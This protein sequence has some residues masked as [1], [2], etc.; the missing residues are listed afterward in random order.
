M[1]VSLS[2]SVDSDGCR[3]IF[4]EEKTK[5]NLKIK[6]YKKISALFCHVAG[7]IRGHGACH[8]A[9]IHVRATGSAMALHFTGVCGVSFSATSLVSHEA[10]VLAVMRT[11]MMCDTGRVMALYFIG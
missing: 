10:I 9:H 7:E 4:T 3:Q 8:G 2:F 1:N 6:N 5:K 11:S